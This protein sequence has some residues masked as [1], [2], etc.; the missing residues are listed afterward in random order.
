MRKARVGDCILVALAIAGAAIYT[1][2]FREGPETRRVLEIR[3]AASGRIYARRVLEEP[4]E[5]A[6]EF[7]HSVH[8]SPVQERFTV[9][10]TTIRPK[11]VRFYSFGAGMASDLEEGQTMS[12]EG[13]ALVISGF[14]VSYH[15]LNYI[16]GT[17]SDHVL[18]IKDEHISLRE[19]CGRNAHISI[20]I[21]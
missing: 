18:I 11:S 21:K 9:E 14:R 17:V 8:Q 7:I 2:C 6:I 10:G 19:L 5:F 3:D 12:R 20:L 4:E 1:A 15:E 16:V 13:D